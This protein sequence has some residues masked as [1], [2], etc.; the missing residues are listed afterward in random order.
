MCAYFFLSLSFQ[1]RK[2]LKL[3]WKLFLYLAIWIIIPL[4]PPTSKS[5]HKVYIARRIPML[6]GATN[7]VAVFISA[8]TNHG[9]RT[10]PFEIQTSKTVSYLC[11]IILLL[12]LLAPFLFCFS[13]FF[14]LVVNVF[15]CVVYFSIFN[16]S[17]CVCVCV[18]YSMALKPKVVHFVLRHQQWPDFPWAT[19]NIEL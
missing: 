18:S 17:L 15:R 2:C 12:L 4:P 8:T 3:N 5:R 1:N 6:L 9:D 13:F 19:H 14:L 7:S 10:K 11:T 16:N